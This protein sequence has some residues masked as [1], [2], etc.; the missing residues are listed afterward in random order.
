MLR[1]LKRNI[2]S[3]LII[4]IVSAVAYL[5]Y[6]PNTFLTGWDTLH[7]ELN[8]SLNFERMFNGVW[9]EEQGLGAVAGHSHMADLPRVVIL[10]LL[11]FAL[12]L[13]SL[14]YFYVFLCLLFGP[15]GMYF[16]LKQILERRTRNIEHEEVLSS[17][18]Y[19]TSTVAFIGSLFYLFNPGTVQQFYAPFEMFTSQYAA[20]PWIVLFSLKYLEHS[21]NKK[22]LWLFGLVTLLAM[23]QAYAAHLW[24]AFFGVYLLFLIIYTVLNRNSY[25]NATSGVKSGNALPSVV[26][27]FTN[28]Q[29]D[30]KQFGMT[31]KAVTLLLLTLLINSLWLLPNI[32]YIA[33]SSSVP[34]ESK[35]NR[36]FSQE[37]RVRN[38]ENGYIQDVALVR[39]FYFQ[40]SVFNFEKNRFEYLMP[41]WRDHLNNPVVASVGYGFFA[42]SLFG[43][44]LAIKEKNRVLK[45]LL[46]FYIL[47]FTLLM[48]STPP[49]SWLFNI[50]LKFSVF[51]EALRFVFTKLSILLIFGYA[52]FI[53]YALLWII[54]KFKNR[55]QTYPAIFLLICA[56]LIYGLPLLRGNLI[57]DKFKVVIPQNYFELWKYM[58]S[59]PMQPVLTLPLHTFSGWQYY[60]WTTSTSKQGYQ[61]SGFIWFGMK[62]P[63]L[64]RDSDR[65]SI[66]NEQSFRELQYTLY[67][68]HY[69]QFYASLEK[70]DIG[71]LV[72]DT[73]VITPTEKNR[74]Q[75]LYQR[76]TIDT[77]KKLTQAG[78]L[79]KIRQFGTILIY[80]VVLPKKPQILKI[81]TQISPSYRWNFIDQAYLDHPEYITT[82][83]HLT[84]LFNYPFRN[85]LTKTDRIKPELT[86]SISDLKHA[87]K[88]SSE[89]I[90]KNQQVPNVI[91]LKKDGNTSV[92]ELRTKNFT[93]GIALQNDTFPHNLGYAIGFR[94]KNIKGLPLRFCIKN[95]YSSLCDTYDELSHSSV[96]TNDYFVIPPYESGHGYGIYIDNISYGDYETINELESVTIYPLYYNYL[97]SQID[98]S[99][100]RKEL[101][102]LHNGSAFNDGWIAFQLQISNFKFQ[103]LKDHVLVNNWENGWVLSNQ[104]TDI[105]GQDL[106]T[107]NRQLIT[108][109]WPQYLEYLGFLLLLAT[110]VTLSFNYKKKS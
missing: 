26:G 57:S 80:K 103:I 105:G 28:N 79:K 20:L 37:Y 98:V 75:I 74:N 78:K 72:W 31:K 107:E 19:A 13:S 17:K 61:G 24:Y 43:I 104:S 7:P 3:I 49:F 54:A 5:T 94:S 46:P 50:L 110:L 73:S 87:I 9:R 86:A 82:N 101:K 81:N 99:G 96:M 97:A 90:I 95:L 23:P 58:E 12:P 102:V 52:I 2:Y 47:P 67:S 89:R 70:Y 108:I 6:R 11:H 35:Q 88:F 36:I 60:N 32:Y 42:L 39:G 45:S 51:E 4:F 41:E 29:D 63:V 93:R 34:K 65:W 83:K 27:S 14:R 84:R 77:I 69:N 1:F 10:W 64:D 92:V 85:F 91:S 53:S 71:Y 68:Q 30:K 8:F 33:T 66:A 56:V 16:L 106:K 25:H 109:F 18:L 15:L 55:K 76:E 59:Q 100:V 21:S 44:Y 22:N 48:N 40:W 62:Q 38:Q